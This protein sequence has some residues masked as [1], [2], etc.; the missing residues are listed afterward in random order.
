[1]NLDQLAK[2]LRRAS[3]TCAIALTIA[4]LW[5]SFVTSDGQSFAV[6]HHRSAHLI[7]FAILAFTWR[8]ALP[9]LPASI[10]TLLIIGFGF[11]QEGIEVFGHVHPFELN[12]ALIDAVGAIIGVL[13]ASLVVKYLHDT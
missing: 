5:I 3:L 9:R 7:S 8:V 1:M 13:S 11:L 12:D 4:L 10:V 2:I 6:K